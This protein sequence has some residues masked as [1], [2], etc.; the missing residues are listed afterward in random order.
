MQQ[1]LGPMRA[2]GLMF[3]GVLVSFSGDV[4]LNIDSRIF[5]FWDPS[6][7]LRA[8]LSLNLP[9]TLL[10]MVAYGME[11]TFLRFG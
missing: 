10:K 3:A 9:S 11:N 1:G 4:C 8:E 7:Q 2:Q 5:D 6:N